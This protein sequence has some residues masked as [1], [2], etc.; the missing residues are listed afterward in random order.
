MQEEQ[1]YS[2]DSNRLGVLT[3]AVLLTYALTHLVNAP[4]LTLTLQLPGFYFAYPLTIGTAM[5]LMAAGLTATG[6]DWLLRNHPSI[7]EGQRTIEHW[8]LPAL[9]AFIV[10]VVLDILPNGLLWWVGFVFGTGIL[11]SVFLA[12]YVAVDPGA[13]AYALASAGLIALSY[14]LFLLF[15]I[16]L[17]LAGARLFLT[18]PAIFLAAGLV[19]LR[20][21]HL[22]L[23]A[24]WEFP[25]ATGVGLVSAQLAAGL[26][27]WPVSSL[28]YGLILL[29]PLYALNTLAYGLSEDVPMRAALREPGIILALVWVSAVFLR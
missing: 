27:Y 22:R 8:L 28:Q 26:H 3:A 13:P 23:S 4:G 14:A 2:P 19:T 12:E 16:A 15:V 1:R 21:L 24:R 18:V 11:V 7:Q 29:G 17:R 6:M 25:W 10:G 5:T 20:T 9:T